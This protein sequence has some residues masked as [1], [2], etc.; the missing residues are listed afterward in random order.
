[1]KKR[2]ITVLI[3]YLKKHNDIEKYKRFIDVWKEND[4]ATGT[5]FETN[6]LDVIRNLGLQ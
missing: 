6:L 1:M 4:N 3:N 2:K 5:Q